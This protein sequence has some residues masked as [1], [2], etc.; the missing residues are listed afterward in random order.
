MKPT[1]INIEVIINR[2]IADV[3]NY[4]TNPQHIVG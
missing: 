1:V 3:W 2:G 4:Y